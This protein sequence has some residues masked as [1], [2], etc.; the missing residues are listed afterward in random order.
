LG[1][2]KIYLR[3]NMLVLENLEALTAKVGQDLGSSNWYEITQADIDAFAQ[4]TGDT[5]WIHTNPEMA[6]QYSPFGTTIAHG[7][8]NLSL[9]PML[10]EKI[11]SIKTVKMGLNYGM[12]KVRFIS[13]VPVGSRLRMHAHLRA[14]EPAP[15]RGLKAFTNVTFELEGASKPACVAELIGIYF[16]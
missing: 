3:K 6:K 12:N 5:Q 14:V 11:L 1:F 4:A 8:Y 13:P 16:E 7:L 9:S 2:F 15:P 10:I